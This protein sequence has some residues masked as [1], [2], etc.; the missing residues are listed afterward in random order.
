MSSPRI[1]AVIVTFNRI[2]E[3]KKTLDSL[4]R[5]TLVPEHIIIINNNS[6]DR[7]REYLKGLSLRNKNLIVINMKENT[8]GAGGLCGRNGSSSYFDELIMGLVNG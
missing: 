8:G 6:K 7:T 3:L 4:F 5:Q 1:C 2:G